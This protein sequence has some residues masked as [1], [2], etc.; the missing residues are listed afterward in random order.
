MDSGFLAAI[1]LRSDVDQLDRLVVEA[2][3]QNLKPG[4]LLRV[5]GTNSRPRATGSGCRSRSAT[6]CRT[7]AARRS[8]WIA[9]ASRGGVGK[10]AASDGLGVNI[11]LRL[12]GAL[13][14]Q[15]TESGHD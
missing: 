9:G 6:A 5:M 11:R 3:E 14:K 15:M 1:G 12:G 10:G 4:S 7:S 13:D 2:V 8:P